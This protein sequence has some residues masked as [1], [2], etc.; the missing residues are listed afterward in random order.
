MSASF[1]IASPD[2]CQQLATAVD[3]AKGVP[4]RPIKWNPKATAAEV[5][6]RRI[7]PVETDGK[8]SGYRV[9]DENRREVEQVLK[10]DPAFKGIEIVEDDADFWPANPAER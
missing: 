10:S 2:L 9:Q 7:A 3:A 8:R 6:T 4:K 1:V 5:T